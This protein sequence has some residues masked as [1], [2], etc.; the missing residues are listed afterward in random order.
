MSSRRSRACSPRSP[1]ASRSRGWSRSRRPCSSVWCRVTDYLPADAAI[2]ILS[3]ERVATRALNLAET[4]REFLEAAW[5]AATAGAEAPIDL[6]SGDFFTVGALRAA[7]RIPPLVDAQPLRRR[8]GGRA[9][10]RGGAG[11]ELRRPG[12]G[13]RRSRRRPAARRL[14]RRDLGRRP[15]ARRARRRRARRAG[16][17]GPGCR[18]VPRGS[19]GR[20]R[21]PAAGLGRGRL[22]AARR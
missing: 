4:N 18:R 6:G 19:G 13:C 15:R 3:P 8:R 20:G 7:C 10:P 21:L 11:P 22:P 14:D 12:R 1:R 17:R 9:A 2:A 16:G 5:S